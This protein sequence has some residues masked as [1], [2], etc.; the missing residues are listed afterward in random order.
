MLQL[1]PNCE[2]CN[3]DLPPSAAEARI[4]SYECTFC[5]ACVEH[6]LH[7]RCPN[8]GGGF[9]PRPI[10]PAAMLTRHPPSTERVFNPQSCTEPA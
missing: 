4:C 2:C 10:R 5:A 8:C 3:R 9:V 6:R 7:G 1:R